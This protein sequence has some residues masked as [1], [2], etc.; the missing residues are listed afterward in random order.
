M[1]E[2]VNDVNINKQGI[3][4]VGTIEEMKTATLDDTGAIDSILS[5]H[6]VEKV[7]YDRHA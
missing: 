2:S 1:N 4:V 6:F 7:K 3:F 5:S